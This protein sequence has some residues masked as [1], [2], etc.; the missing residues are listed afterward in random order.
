MKK[1]FITLVVLII[2]QCAAHAQCCDKSNE[3]KTAEKACCSATSP[4]EKT[5]V[6]A[7][8]FHTSRRCETC[9]AVEAVSKEAAEEY[10]K[11]KVPFLSVDVEDESQQALIE[12]Y[13]VSGQTLLIVGNDKKIDLTNDAFLNART[14]PDKLKEKIKQTIDSML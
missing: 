14:N 11:T 6:T 4:E 1:T 13:Q 5:T 7:Y 10:S 8:Y 12:K 3:V 2:A 9:K